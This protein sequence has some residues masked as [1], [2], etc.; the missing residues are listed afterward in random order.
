MISTSSVA[1]TPTAISEAIFAQKGR[2]ETRLLIVVAS[3][4][5][6]GRREEA[7]SRAKTCKAPAGAGTNARIRIERHSVHPAC[8]LACVAAV[9]RESDHLNGRQGRWM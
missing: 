2:Y 1:R 4:V 3:W 9:C 8:I 6:R 5:L 7:M